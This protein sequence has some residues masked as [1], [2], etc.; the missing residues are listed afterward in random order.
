M[1][2]K[3]KKKL[4][5]IVRAA[6]FDPQTINIEART[7]D[8]IF[9]TENP[10]RMYSWAMDG[11]FD[12]IL[13]MDPSN[14]RMDRVNSGMPVLDNHNR[15]GGAAGV[16]GIVENVNFANQ[17][18]RATLRFSKRDDVEPIFQDV[19]DGIL[20]GISVGYR[21]HKY[22]EMNP[23]RA[24]GETPQYRAID[25]EPM[26]I[27]F[28]PIQ[29]DPKSAV[30]AEGVEPNDFEIV[31]TRKETN[32]IT[33]TPEEIQA[34][35][36]AKRNAPPAPTPAPAPTPVN[37]DEVRA[38]ATAAERD[39]VK[40]IT[41]S[42]RKAGLED[43]FAAELIENGSSI[44]AARAAII[45]KFAEADPN[46]GQRSNAT[47]TADEGDKRRNATIDAL[48]LRAMPEASRDAKIMS[49][50]RVE[51][52]R[53]HR[54]STLLDLAK[55][56]LIR[57]GVSIDGLDKMD[58]VG[59]AIT[60]SSSDFPVLLEGTNRRVLLAAY[61][62]VADVWS[63]FCMTGSVSDFRANK[64]LRM[65]SFS[66]LDAVNENQEY[67][68]KAISDAESESIIATTKGNIIN[69][70][71][72]M[73][74]NDD[75]AGFTRLAQMLGR[76][77]ARSVEADVFALL[78]ANPTMGDGIA[79]FHASHNNI[80]TGSALTVTGLDADRV[81]MA[82]QKDP[83]NNDYI[84]IRPS[85]LLV[86]SSLEGTAKVLNGSQ[87]DPDAANKL[88]RPNIVA[89]LFG[90]IVSTPR[91][92]GT[93][94]YMFASASEEPVI[95]VAF[96]DGVQTPY[97]ESEQAFKV[98]GMSWK[99]RMDYGVGAIGWRGVIRNAGV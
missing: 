58:I 30:R 41:D 79:L 15:W 78:A 73:I 26:E 45:E 81:Q 32:H 91:L 54:G 51:A 68:T 89:G 24:A 8:V 85:V 47:V 55:D 29:A 56:S 37:V 6:S 77:A 1:A 42:V 31:T 5:P 94:R 34:A 90:D 21:V 2:D 75:L 3:N 69:V 59:R 84:G 19:K 35:E 40:A 7:V 39:R 38:A 46:K 49:T 97:M 71:R 95:E 53:A 76:A 18:G 99:V 14:I 22:M 86:P 48:V 87:Y 11:Y 9:A 10:V 28:A 44:D 74:I 13:S 36:D 96:L 64:R 23:L 60:S 82:S 25:W 98:D 20:R 70:S 92:S 65:G 27:S 12:E 80:G 52:A 57:S 43:K 88:Q 62:S 72:Q 33:M 61:Q 16:L 17:E 50:D 67:K 83:G 66:N 63:R 93:T 4:D